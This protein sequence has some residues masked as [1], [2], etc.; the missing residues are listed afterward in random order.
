[1]SQT[2]DIEFIQADHVYVPGNCDFVHIKT[3]IKT[4]QNSHAP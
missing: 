3:F 1:M 4:K 2:I